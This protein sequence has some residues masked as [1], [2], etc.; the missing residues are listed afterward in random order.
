MALLRRLTVSEQT[1]AHLRTELERGLRSG[2][3]PGVKQLAKELGV[4][5]KTVDAALRQLQHEGLLEGQGQGRRWRIVPP[6][7]Q[8]ARPMRIAIFEYDPPARTEAVTVELHHLFLAAGHSAF[9]TEQTLVELE[10]DVGRISRL[11]RK[12]KAD[13]WVIGSASREV[14]EWF[15]AQ[16]VP[17]FALFGRREGLPIAGVGPEKIPV[18]LA[19][20]RHLI[21]LGHRSIVQLA[22]RERR[23]PVPG[24][25]ER[26]I[27]E[28]LKAHGIPAGPFNLPDW[29][30][31]R[32]GF[33]ALLSSLF[34]V[35]PPTAFI[36]GEAQ[37]FT[38]TLQFLANRG[39]RVPQQV[40]LL[41]TDAD[42]AFA[43]GTPPVSH[44]RW[45]SAP[46]IRRVVQWAA[47]VTHG[48]KDQRQT[49]TPAEFVGGGTI[50]PCGK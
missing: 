18:M 45:D 17:A 14:L 11:A 22:R 25:A 7:G 26:A 23:E 44:I 49:L 27:L 29:E 39:L 13:A 36:I 31:T 33:Q 6:N 38:A 50:G 40:S 2:A 41:C 28:E 42:P 10:M 12:T 5:P 46:V 21:G 43:W 35:T 47:N 4:D 32:E 9:F 15:I 30:E 1:A 37:F 34:R 8:T 3:M 20:T 19:A 16:P 48:K 24:I